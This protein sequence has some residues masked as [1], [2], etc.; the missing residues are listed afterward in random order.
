LSVK[1]N[2]KIACVLAGRSAVEIWWWHFWEW[3][4]KTILLFS[5]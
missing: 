4:E 3:G 5:I 1:N 2:N